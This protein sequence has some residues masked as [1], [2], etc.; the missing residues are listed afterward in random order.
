MKKKDY[1]LIAGQV[2]DEIH[3][4]KNR[5]GIS[6]VSHIIT[7]LSYAF[8]VNDFKFD[9]DKFFVACGLDPKETIV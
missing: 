5:P 1:V 6:H 3:C 7:R 9:S 8:Q 2:R 4:E